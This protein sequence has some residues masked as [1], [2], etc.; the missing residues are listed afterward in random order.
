MLA[1]LSGFYRPAIAAA[2]RIAGES[3]RWLALLLVVDFRGADSGERA[4]ADG[5]VGASQGGLSA[6]GG[7]PV[8]MGLPSWGFVESPDGPTGGW[9]QRLGGSVGW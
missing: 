8:E 4:V 5:G 3:F 7:R 2:R 1:S 6:A 9:R